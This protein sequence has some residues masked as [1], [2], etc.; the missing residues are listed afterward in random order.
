VGIDGLGELGR[1]YRSGYGMQVGRRVRV[2]QG[3][4]ARLAVL[5]PVEPMA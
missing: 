4:R 1:K 5:V 2:E 3:M